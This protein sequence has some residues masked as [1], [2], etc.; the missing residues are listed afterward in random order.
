MNISRKDFFRRGFLSLGEAVFTVRDALTPPTKVPMEITDGDSFTAVPRENQV[1]VA[2]NEHCLGKNC[3]CFAC[4]EQC[5]PEAIQLIPGVGIEINP[6]R[7]T[8][9]GSCEYV[10]PVTPKA[11]SREAR[12][13]IN[14][15]PTEQLP[16]RGE[17]T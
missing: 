3:G 11:V 2:F 4:M 17:T 16:Q 1:A 15:A 12:P 6:H 5:E 10:C 13:N 8:G 9:C 14:H 7:C